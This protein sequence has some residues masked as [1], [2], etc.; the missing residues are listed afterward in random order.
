MACTR[1][2]P[3]ER[4]HQRRRLFHGT[5]VLEKL[6]QVCVLITAHQ[7]VIKNALGNTTN[8]AYPWHEMWK[9][10]RIWDISGQDV[11]K[12]D[13]VLDTPYDPKRLFEVKPPLKEELE[14]TLHPVESTYRRQ[15]KIPFRTEA[16]LVSRLAAT[17]YNS[18]D[19]S[20]RFLAAYEEVFGQDEDWLPRNHHILYTEHGSSAQIIPN[21]E[22]DRAGVRRDADI[23]KDMQPNRCPGEIKPSYKFRAAWIEQT[24]DDEIRRMRDGITTECQKVCAQ[25][26]FYM[27][28][29]GCPEIQL[30]AKYGYILTDEEVVL[31]RRRW[32]RRL[33]GR[34]PEEVLEL[35]KPFKMRGAA[36]GEWTAMMAV[37]YIHLL[38]GGPWHLTTDPSQVD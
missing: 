26:R 35:T 24:I 37:L 4:S 29:C 14:G 15:Y 5:H 2:L 19:R 6:H 13:K 36:P 8:K 9:S 21:F 17:F 25:L 7:E 27:K 33:T 18:L 28:N 22:P 16:A 10:I 12:F 31:A 23:E 38:G 32:E 3:V 20:L 1:V 11:A 30:G 34:G